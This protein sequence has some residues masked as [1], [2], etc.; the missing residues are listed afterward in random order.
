MLESAYRI[1]HS[2]TRVIDG[3]DGDDGYQIPAVP[4]F[5][6]VEDSSNDGS[7]GEAAARFSCGR[8][9]VPFG[10]RALQS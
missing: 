10:S 5:Y 7:A 3:N 1:G 9:Q 6:N 4:E 8:T 2:G